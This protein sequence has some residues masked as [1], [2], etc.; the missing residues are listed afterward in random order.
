MPPVTRCDEH[1]YPVPTFDLGKGDINDITNELKGFHEQFYDC[2]NV[3]NPENTSQNIWQANSVHWN[4]N[5]LNRLLWQL[6][7]AMSG[8]CRGLLVMPRGMVM[9]SYPSI[10]GC[11]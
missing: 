11:K 4:G 9:T 1:L 2:S 8:R 5:P 7:M 3:V 6:K 10:V